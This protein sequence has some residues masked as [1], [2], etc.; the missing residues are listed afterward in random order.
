MAPFTWAGSF[1]LCFLHQAI[2]HTCR[3][4]QHGEV[5]NTIKIPTDN[6]SLSGLLVCDKG[7]ILRTSGRHPITAR[8][9]TCRERDGQGWKLQYPTEDEG[10][11]TKFACKLTG[12]LFC[13]LLLLSLLLLLLLFFF[14][15]FFF[16][17][18]LFLFLFLFLLFL[19]LLVDNLDHPFSYHP[20]TVAVS[21]YCVLTKGNMLWFK[22]PWGHACACI[23]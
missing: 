4:P 3:R 8:R 12:E 6:K 15:F 14:F 2:N 7:Y 11:D 9:V 13:L 17:F 10:S 18:F 16:F 20:I 23:V 1:V 5:I 21:R 22:S 19:F